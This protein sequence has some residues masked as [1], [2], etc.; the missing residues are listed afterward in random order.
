VNYKAV[1]KGDEPDLPLLANDVVMV[2][3]RLF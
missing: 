2:G 1:R 3:R